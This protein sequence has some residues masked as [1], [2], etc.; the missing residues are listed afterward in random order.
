MAAI[1]LNIGGDTRQLDRDIQKTVNRVYSINLKTKG[2][3]PLGRITGKVNE[4]EKSLAASNARVIAFGASAGIIY[5]V[6]SAFVSLATSVVEVQ[7][8][9]QDINVILNVSTTQLNKFGGELFNIAK[10]TGQSFKNV[11]EAATEFS[12]QGLGLEETLKRTNEALILSRLSGLDTVKSV[13]ALTAAV[14][15]FAS[16]A[17]T[18]TQIVNK[19]ATVDAAFAVSS[20][21]LADAISRVG[22]SAAQSG[23]NLDELIAIVTSAQQTT[24]RGGAVIG[25]SFKTIFTRLQRGKVVDLLESLGISG[26]S[27]SG[28][29]KSTIQLL[30]ELGQVYDKLGAGQQAYVAEQVGGVFQINILKAALSDLGKEYSIYGN[31]LKTSLTATDQAIQRNDELNKTFAAQL[32]ALK[33][34]ITQFSGSI[35]ES[36][37]APLFDRT[38]GNLN[39]LLGGINEGDANSFGGV[40]GKGIL[41][42]LGQVLAGPGLALVG[43]VL[44]KLFRDFSIYASGSLKDLLGL[45]SAAKQQGELQKS[46]AQIISKNPELYALMQKGA[47]GLNQASQ[48]LLQNLKAQT[49]ELATQQKLSAVIAKQ[50]YGSG[51]RFSG[52]VPVAP[53]SGKPGKVGKAAGYIPNFASDRSIEKYTAISLGATS[54]VRPHMSQGKIDGSKFVMNSQ[55][56]EFPG[57]GKNGDSMVLPKYGDGPK[58][59]AAGYI[60]NFA[61]F[62]LNGLKIKDTQMS[63]LKAG[64]AIKV[65]GKNYTAESLGTTAAELKSNPKFLPAIEKQ[66]IKNEQKSIKKEEK[67]IA[68]GRLLTSNNEYAAIVASPGGVTPFTQKRFTPQGESLKA[69]K[70]KGSIKPLNYSFNA[71]GADNFQESSAKPSFEQIIENNLKKAQQE[72]VNRYQDTKGLQSQRF[73]NQKSKSQVSSFAGFLFEDIVSSFLK[74][75][76]FDSYQKTAPDARFDFKSSKTLEDFFGI[77][78]SIKAVEAKLNTNPSLMTSASNTSS[79]ANKIYAVKG[80]FALSTPTIQEREE[81]KKTS[82]KKL[83]AAAGYIPNFAAQ[84]AAEKREMSVS[85]SPAVPLYSNMLGSTVVVNEGQI[86]KYGPNAD[87]IIQKDHIN[88]GQ[89][90]TRSNLM[91][92]GSGKE[93]YSSGKSRGFIPNFA[94]SESSE[95]A[96]LVSSIAALTTQ[97]GGLAFMLSFSKDGIKNSLQEMVDSQKTASGMTV[98]DTKLKQG[99]VQEEIT[100][101]QAKQAV[102]KE[103]MATV[104]KGSKE[105]KELAKEHA[106]ATKEVRKLSQ[107]QSSLA[108]QIRGTKNK[109]D[110]GTATKSQK[111]GAAIGGNAMAIGL[112]APILA[113]TAKNAIG[114]ESRSART[115]GAIA[116]GLGSTVSMAAL[117]GTVGGVPGAVVGGAVGATMGFVDVIKQASTDLPEFTAASQKASEALSRVT[118]SSQNILTGFNQLE[119]LKGA[120]SEKQAAELKANLKQQVMEKFEANPTDI[121]GAAKASAAIESG[122][123]KMLSEALEENNKAVT[124]KDAKAKKEEGAT[125]FREDNTGGVRGKTGIKNF[126]ESFDA[127]V[128]KSSNLPTL[129]GEKLQEFNQQLSE[130]K[131]GDMFKK[132]PESEKLLSDLLSQIGVTNEDFKKL[133]LESGTEI[134]LAFASLT[135]TV[136]RRAGIEKEALKDSAQNSDRL[137]VLTNVL[138]RVF[139]QYRGISK[140]AAANAK[141]EFQLSN[142]RKELSAEFGKTVLEGRSE[143]SKTLGVSSSGQRSIANQESVLGINKEYDK[144]ITENLEPINADIADFIRNSFDSKQQKIES[145]E[146]FEGDTN[147]QRTEEQVKQAQLLNPG[148]IGSDIAAA[149]GTIG[150]F[151]AGENTFNLKTLEAKL[152]AGLDTNDKDATAKLQEILQKASAANDAAKK[153]E[154][155]RKAQLAILAQ[156]NMNQLAQ[157]FAAATVASFG[158]FQA[159]YLDKDSGDKSFATGVGD[160][161]MERQRYVDAIQRGGGAMSP[162]ETQE[163]GRRSGNVYSQIEKMVGRPLGGTATGQSLE[164]Q[165]QEIAGRAAQLKEQRAQIQSEAGSDPAVAQA[166]LEASRKMANQTGFGDEFKRI[167]ASTQEGSKERT[168]QIDDLM[169]RKGGI[170]DVT[171]KTQS[172]E[173]RKTAENE[174]RFFNAAKDALAPED[175][176][177]LEDAGA[178]GMELWKSQSY[179]NT[180]A[181]ESKKLQEAAN[182]HLDEIKKSIGDALARTQPPTPPAPAAQGA[183]SASN[184]TTVS[185]TVNINVNGANG[186]QVNAEGM[187]AET[188]KVLEENKDRILAAG[189]LADKVANLENAV[190]SQNPNMRPPPRGAN[191]G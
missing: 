146:G 181:A 147:L 22:S 110:V 190:Y 170:L 168:T 182:Q 166:L 81:F 82:Q 62:V 54:S 34:N 21:D 178:D 152:S 108:S 188:A 55:E 172:D 135:E 159:E 91:K 104:K 83:K 43:G 80:G 44:I 95:P 8:S 75:S 116:S 122:D 90:G 31:A 145:K 107:A 72:I 131:I 77:P 69:L 139:S 124:E 24:A 13:E 64:N 144:T 127:N 15:S 58:I 76:E 5:G 94:A 96:D 26:T 169:N 25:N 164:L 149:M 176:K 53:T 70:G 189:G 153:A 138:A 163:L 129:T 47:T 19:F 167:L 148:T 174:E 161:M 120:G 156:Q 57:V 4:F 191:A 11:A 2:D 71:Y 38:V 33:Q 27:A 12:R 113:E 17:V 141:L 130:I 88:K 59:A 173:L 39:E 103:E 134:G 143:V 111:F 74:S 126:E 175:R 87:K 16:Q 35:G 48:T 86:K 93:K 112:I 157:E 100:A 9:L 154:Q 41:D 123:F 85:G 132:G 78:S 160:A 92:T 65:N 40:L 97:L 151:G 98:A 20:A 30:T 6:Q 66:R 73:T 117:G 137:R 150:A 50:L 121:K 140:N 29:V 49:L 171:A 42:G 18:A 101:A 14:N 133:G 99:L 63:V 158:G 37:L 89:V 115:G 10:N 183:P 51:V 106:K 36:L 45:N 125:K 187:S 185:P 136:S 142:Q 79:I 1:N 184:N 32:N 109:G 56:D 23:V 28:E 105:A 61:N 114:G 67:D 118:E 68:S 84:A 180:L 52:G 179:G 102:I 7:K 128:L 46:I 177:R 155:T 60:P 186:A 3:Q 162:E 119:S 165:N